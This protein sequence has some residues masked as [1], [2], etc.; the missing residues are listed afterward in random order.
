MTTLIII[1]FIIGYILIALSET[2]G[3]NKAAIALL[4]GVILWT[5]YIFSG[6]SLITGA[7]PVSF[8]EFIQS[9]PGIGQYSPAQQAIKYVSG[10]KIID[11]LGNTAEILFYLLGAM[12]SMEDSPESRIS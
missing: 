2:I 8:H 11:A 3:I 7:S 10:L 1:I 9:T 4:L 12:T 6:V 5:L